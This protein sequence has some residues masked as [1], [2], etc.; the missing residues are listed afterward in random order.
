MIFMRILP[1]VLKELLKHVPTVL[2]EAVE[3]RVLSHELPKLSR[4]II[5]K[6]GYAE[7]FD[8]QKTYLSP[9]KINLVPEVSKNFYPQDKKLAAQ[10]ILTLYFAQLFS[11]HGI[12]LD[13]GPTHLEM[14]GEELNIHPN[15]VW[16]KF[17]PEFADGITDIYDGFYEEDDKLF[18]QGLIKSGLSSTKWPQKDRDAL[19]QLFKS[20]FGASVSGEMT[21]ELETFK[22]S[23]LKVADFML[24][25]KVK[26]ST[27][28]IYLGIAL[29]TMYS[30]LE[31]T[32]ASVNVKQLYLDVKKLL[33]SNA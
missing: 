26:I 17:S 1:G 16:T 13:I 21:F 9:F 29:V 11:P 14:N 25:K 5:Q 30:S 31:H 23:F 20:H 7:L 22:K 4:R 3:W 2:F 24:E 19:A 12:F 28:F 18:H 33:P 10:C 32:K 27:D 6:E 15:G 8:L